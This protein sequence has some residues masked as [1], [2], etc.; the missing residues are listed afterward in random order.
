[1]MI[2]VRPLILIGE[3]WRKSWSAILESNQ[4]MIPS[5]HAAYLQFAKDN[6]EAIQ[7]L[8]QTLLK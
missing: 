2:V 8:K 3:G 7:L 4:D 5:A 6:T 1:M